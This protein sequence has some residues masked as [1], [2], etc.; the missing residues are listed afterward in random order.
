MLSAERHEVKQWRVRQ[1]EASKKAPQPRTTAGFKQWLAKST[2]GN[3]WHSWLSEYLRLNI[4]SEE[5]TRNEGH[6]C[7]V[8]HGDRTGF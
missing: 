2:Q 8:G 6:E 7:C 3:R 5:V 4:F 1:Y